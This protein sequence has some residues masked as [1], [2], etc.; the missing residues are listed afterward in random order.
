MSEY[1]FVTLWHVR[2]PIDLVWEELFHSERWPRW[3]KGLE[4]VVEVRRGD[5]NSVGSIR[6]FTWKGRLPYTLVVD[7]RVTR[8]EPPVTLESAASGELEGQGLWRLSHDEDGTMV[9]YEWNVRTTKRWM[10]VLAPLAR[11]LFR[12]NHDMVMRDGGKGLKQLLEISVA[13]EQVCPVP[14]RGG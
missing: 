7:M 11:P 6:R 5:D 3:W 4:R 12:W 14:A 13:R 10:N 1:A 8:V 2:A 9:R